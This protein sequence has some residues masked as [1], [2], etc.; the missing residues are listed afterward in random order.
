VS[1][2]DTQF[3]GFAK[4]LMQE[5]IALRGYIDIG[6]YSDEDALSSASDYVEIITQ[7]SYDL[8]C[9]IVEHVSESMAALR[10]VESMSV[11]ECVNEIPDMTEWPEVKSE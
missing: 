3:A 1:E 11:Q 5:M 6:G 8:A 4:L 10:E 2:R 9:H 7:Y